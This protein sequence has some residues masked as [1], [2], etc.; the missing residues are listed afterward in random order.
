MRLLI[1][2]A[3]LL[4]ATVAL[5]QDPFAPPGGGSDPFGP[6][7]PVT[8]G[9]PT[10]AP[11]ITFQKTDP[12][13]A[14]IQ[15]RTPADSGQPPAALLKAAK[16]LY[17]YRQYELAEK[18]FEAL[19][20][21]SPAAD[22]LVQ[23]RNTYGT[24]FFLNLMRSD[25]L[26]QATRD[27]ANKLV[28]DADKASRDP[29]RIADL[30]GKLSDASAGERNFAFQ[31]L[32]NI[33]T[34]AIVEMVGVLADGARKSEHAAMRSALTAMGDIAIAPVMGAL[35]SNNDALMVNAASVLGRLKAKE[36]TAPL[37]ALMHHP[38]TSASV[39]SAAG[40]AVEAIVGVK[41]NQTDAIRYLRIQ[42]EEAVQVVLPE[43]ETVF[44]PVTRWTWDAKTNKPVARVFPIRDAGRLQATRIAQTLFAIDPDD[45]GHRRKYLQAIFQS[46]VIQTG[47]GN[48]LP[49]GA[50][51]AMDVAKA[52][53][54]ELLS[55]AL[56]DAMKNQQTLAAIG[57]TQAI[58]A[59]G[60]MA[61]LS[62]TGGELSPLASA[63]ENRNQRLRFTAA[64]AVM[65]IDP[66]RGYA[67]SSQFVD[68]LSEAIQ[69]DK[70]DRAIVAMP[71]LAKAQD[72]VAILGESGYAANSASTGRGA[73]LAAA[74]KPN[75]QFILVSLEIDNPPISHL[76]QALRNDSRTADIP[77]GIMFGGDDQLVAEAIANR[78][79]GVIALPTPQSRAFLEF[80]A[81][82]MI[83]LK[84][85]NHVPGDERAAQASVAVA[86]ADKL[87]HDRGAYSFYDLH[88]LE[89]PL[90]NALVS[91]NVGPTAASALS[92]LGTPTA[93][94]QLVDVASG[95][96]SLDLRQAAAAAFAD[97]IEE[98][99]LLLSEAD[100]D[101]QYQRYNQ[102]EFEPKSTQQVLGGILDAME[103]PLITSQDSPQESEVTP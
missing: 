73:F 7:D 96:R 20:A 57:L 67:G 24:G 85:R 45:T 42:A 46:A 39:K 32:R 41:P 99:G 47:V 50:G 27:F 35:D 49:T 95:Y 33:G 19:I 82:Q 100:I 76:I 56:D 62:S 80:K 77:V 87:L 84:G 66:Q 86:Y 75:V 90:L 25:N 37:V 83:A 59:R 23:M 44:E 101:L 43:S 65:Q 17:D 71:Q 51:S 88:S 63:L 10:A 98:Y 22:E 79:V 3:V 78:F 26:S 92:G 16:M 11:D 103:A 60:D 5:A 54:L 13:I 4:F 1:S 53:P 58:G 34:E 2:T 72:M 15:S 14:A 69:A 93:Q 55:D 31:E 9:D 36:A 102:S 64:K 94:K 8:P 18:Y 40:D 52:F 74:N 21:S 12:V 28:S 89:R 61:A 29:A 38:A 97:A 91:D 81:R 68:A 6:T 70:L 30:I 48:D